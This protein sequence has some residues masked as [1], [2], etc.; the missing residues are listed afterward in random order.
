[1]DLPFKNDRFN[2]SYRISA[3]EYTEDP[4]KAINEMVRVTQKGGGIVFTMDINI[5]NTDSVSKDD[6]SFVQ[7]NL[8]DL[9]S[10]AY[11][12]KI[13]FPSEILA[14]INRSINPQSEL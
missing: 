9:C 13:F 14:F 1:M 4:V 3:K 10:P 12:F 8:Y 2:L 6:F 11:P 7:E 5:K